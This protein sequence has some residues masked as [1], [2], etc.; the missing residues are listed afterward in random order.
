MDSKALIPK[1]Q[2]NNLN[3]TKPIDY[4]LFITIGVA[5]SQGNMILNEYINETSNYT[6]I[7]A[8]SYLIII[9]IAMVPGI[10]LGIWKRPRGYGYLFGYVIGGFIEVVVGDT[11]IGIYT[12]FVSFML[13]II[14]HLI[15]KHWRS[16]SKVKFE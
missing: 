12:A 13:I 16:V 15:F 7:Q 4:W 1:E 11:Y 5:V 14:P 6:Y 3:P 8:I 9:F 10:V 2:D